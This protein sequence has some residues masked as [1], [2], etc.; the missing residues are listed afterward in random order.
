MGL[1]IKLGEKVI[2]SVLIDVLKKAASDMSLET[3]LETVAV[4]AR[5]G[6][7]K[8]ECKENIVIWMSFLKGRLN[9]KVA[10]I[11]GIS[12]EKEY[13]GFVLYGCKRGY[14]MNGPAYENFDWE[15]YLSLVSKYLD[16]TKQPNN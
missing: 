3:K 7:V 11:E 8:L 15:K 2:G 10:G 6:S 12:P 9:N 1:S 5:L 13:D 14:A 16:Q 4:G